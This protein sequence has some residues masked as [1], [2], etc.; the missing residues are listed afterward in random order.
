MKNDEAEIACVKH[1]VS[2]L[3]KIS[4]VKSRGL[5]QDHKKATEYMDLMLPVV[6]DL[7]R[8]LE[9]DADSVA[10]LPNNVVAFTRP[11]AR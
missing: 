8:M 11:I 3:T 10:N 1:I 6:F 2:Y 9:E 5:P 7:N 4:L